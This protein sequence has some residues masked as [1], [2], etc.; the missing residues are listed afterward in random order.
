MAK[1]I[2]FYPLK[3]RQHIQWDRDDLVGTTDIVVSKLDTNVSSQFLEDAAY[4]TISS[5]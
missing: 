3:K 4:L 2:L 1:I 5:S